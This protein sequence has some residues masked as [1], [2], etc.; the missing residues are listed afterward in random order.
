[1]D[2]TSGRFENS[3]LDPIEQALVRALVSCLVDEWRAGRLIVGDRDIAPSSVMPGR[4]AEAVE[5]RREDTAQV[6]DR[7]E[8]YL[9]RSGLKQRSLAVV[10]L[11][12]DASDR[13]Y[14]R[15]VL[16][17]APS[18]VLSMHPASPRC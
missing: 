3:A 16:R 1:M 9:Q 6:R 5:E 17:D 11:T 4:D 2:A 14:F 15:V 7:L 10:P 13:R 12:G 18:V 8:N